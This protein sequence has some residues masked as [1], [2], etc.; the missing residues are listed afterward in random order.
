MHH[1]FTP[2]S[3][4][5]VNERG[6]RLLGVSEGSGSVADAR[7]SIVLAH[8]ERGIVVVQN[9]RRSIWELPGGY[10]DRGERAADCALRELF[11]ESGLTGSEI[12]LLGVLDIERP[13]PYSDILKCALFQCRAEGAPSPG[14]AEILAVAFWEPMSRLGPISTIDAA[15]LRGGLREC[16]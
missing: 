5:I 10:V 7:V 1:M 6:E 14:D 15:I 9:S 4:P 2:L 11:E 16:A 13:S 3:K 8:H 12:A